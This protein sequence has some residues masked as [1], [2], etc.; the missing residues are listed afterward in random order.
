MPKLTVDEEIAILRS[1]IGMGHTAGKNSTDNTCFTP[2]M[3]DCFKFMRYQTVVD[4]MDEMAISASLGEL[5]TSQKMMLQ[6]LKE[7]GI[8]DAF[9]HLNKVKS[10]EFDLEE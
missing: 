6:L 4:M 9:V 8:I 5:D 3:P 2:F 1:G 7:N 10:G